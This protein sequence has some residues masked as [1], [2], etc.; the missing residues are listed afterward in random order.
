MVM[1]SAGLRIE[2]TW[3]RVRLE[4]DQFAAQTFVLA[5]R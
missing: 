5:Q 2:L 1:W 3:G 4:L